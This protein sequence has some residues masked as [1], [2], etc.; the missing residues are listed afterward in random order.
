MKD[1][2]IIVKGDILWYHIE[3]DKIKMMSLLGLHRM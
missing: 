1:I 2:F 3:G